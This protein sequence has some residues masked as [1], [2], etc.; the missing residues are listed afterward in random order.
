[1]Q[2]GLNPLDNLAWIPSNCVVSL[3]CGSSWRAVHGERKQTKGLDVGEGRTIPGGDG[4]GEALSFDEVCE[5][6]RYHDC[7]EEYLGALGRLRSALSRFVTECGLERD[8]E[9]ARLKR[10]E[11]R[12]ETI[13]IDFSAATRS[14]VRATH[15]YQS[16]WGAFRELTE[17]VSA[18]LEQAFID[19]RAAMY[20]LDD[21][22]DVVV[23][24]FR[25]SCHGGQVREGEQICQALE[26]AAAIAGTLHDEL[27]HV[28]HVLRDMNIEAASGLNCGES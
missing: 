18:R 4:S 20:L 26:A 22:Q 14:N 15:Q 2:A 12:A 27:D 16:R 25:A 6:V 1:M 9:E 24:L 13:F 8:F 3:Q 28:E 21:E 11:G 23:A 10:F 17:Q 19:L 5:R 7:V